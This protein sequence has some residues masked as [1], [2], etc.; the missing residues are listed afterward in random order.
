MDESS[1]LAVHPDVE[2]VEDIW[3]YI[4]PKFRRDPDESAIQK[5]AQAKLPHEGEL[6]LETLGAGSLNKVY[7]LVSSDGDKAYVFRV[8]C[9]IDAGS[10]TKGEVATIK[11][12]KEG[13]E[14]PVPEIIAYDST[15]SNL[16][17]YEWILTDY[18]MGESLEKK[19]FDLDLAAKQ[20]LVKDFA[21]FMA[22]TYNDRFSSGQ[23]GTL[24]ADKDGEV[25]ELVSYFLI[26]GGHFLE[27]GSSKGP[28]HSSADWLHACLDLREKEF[29]SNQR[30]SNLTV[31]GLRH[32]ETALEDI[33]KILRNIRRLRPYVD[34]VFTGKDET[35]LYHDDL[36]EGNILV[37][38]EGRL[39]AII[40][41]EC[42]SVVP[43]WW[44]CQHP[45]FLVGWEQ[46]EK[47]DKTKF[48][49]DWVPKHK[50]T[51]DNV[52]ADGKTSKE[53]SQKYWEALS[54]YE[55]TQLRKTFDQ[56]MESQ[57][58]GWLKVYTESFL[59]RKLGDAVLCCDDPLQKE[60]IRRWLD[61][62]DSGDM[63]AEL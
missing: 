41:W 12:V 61:K 25:G 45:G 11:W 36:N 35:M 7:K 44:A 22:A 56:E 32:R 19:F 8:A 4:S 60:A 1:Q 10:K 59:K 48:G 6:K 57:A 49:H 29:V 52:R 27:H 2:W 30:E 15:K 63:Q 20:P 62:L 46:E 55:T 33:E 40:D 9:P 31:P 39:Q 16:V 21:R 51:K 50:R 47:P 34:M 17:G 18:I 38:E 28:F 3:G 53:I 24:S 54:A 23:I 42:V 13:C 5:E 37:D 58:P 43:L 14:V 26:K